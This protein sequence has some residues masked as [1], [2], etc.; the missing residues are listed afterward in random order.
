VQ[1][2]RG[3]ET[4]SGKSAAR[5][6]PQD[7]RNGRLAVSE[8]SCDRCNA[9]ATLA[10]E[11]Q[12]CVSPPGWWSR[13]ARLYLAT[14][15][16]PGFPC[17]VLFLAGRAR[18]KAGGSPGLGSSCAWPQAGSSWAIHA[19]RP[20]P[21]RGRLSHHSERLETPPRARPSP[22]AGAPL[23]EPSEKRC[24]RRYRIRAILRNDSV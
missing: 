21:A 9:A 10:S 20:K 13:E 2:C 17:R 1:Q 15:W 23:P 5:A 6:M 14:S 24:L 16:T 4:V 22:R 18:E 12:G 3:S 11:A 7:H 8:N 19:S